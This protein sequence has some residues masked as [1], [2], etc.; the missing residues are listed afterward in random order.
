MEGGDDDDEKLLRAATSAR[1]L[2]EF[3]YVDDECE[4]LH[5]L[6]SPIKLQP[7]SDGLLSAV[8]CWHAATTLMN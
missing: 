8:M 5:G 7:A 6:S 4:E 2:A 1:F 3:A